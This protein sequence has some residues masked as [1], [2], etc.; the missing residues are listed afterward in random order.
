MA[1]LASLGRFFWI[2]ASLVCTIDLTDP[3][4]PFRKDLSVTDQHL[5]SR[6]RRTL[7]RIFQHPM[8]MNLHWR[9]VIHLFEG[10]GAQVDQ[11]SK[12]KLKVS[13][14]GAERSFRPHHHKTVSRKDEVVELRHF[15][16]EAGC[17]P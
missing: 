3:V 16:E 11:A 1:C 7:E 4:A 2:R 5:S 13:L 17:K 12:D 6:N 14:N 9:D 8:A 15:L 10:L